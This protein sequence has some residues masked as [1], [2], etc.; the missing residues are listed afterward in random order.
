MS[1]A[2][3]SVAVKICLTAALLAGVFFPPKSLAHPHIFVE[4]KIDIVFD[5]NGLAGFNVKWVFDE[6]FTVMVLE[7]ILELEDASMNA[8]H[9]PIVK[10]QAFDH[11]KEHDYF[12]KVSINNQDFKVQFVRDFNARI[13]NQRLVYEFFAPCHVKAASSWKTV[14]LAQYDP[15][16]YSAL[17]LGEN[18]I[19]VKNAGMFFVE[20]ETAVNK[21]KSYYYGMLHPW[22]TQIRFKRKNG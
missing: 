13:E 22:E 21:E 12:T 16:F 5:E 20:H 2:A 3:G 6:M 1:H 15:T 17:T 14:T 7:E 10:K 11:L 18:P 8:G 9:V 19:T 4:N